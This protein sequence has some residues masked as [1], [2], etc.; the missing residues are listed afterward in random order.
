MTIICTLLYSLKCRTNLLIVLC[1]GLLSVLCLLSSCTEAICPETVTDIQ[2]DNWKVMNTGVT[3]TLR[4]VDFPG[5]G[6]IGYIC[7]TNGT[8]LKTM[9]GGQSFFSL[10]SGTTE[11]LYKVKFVT[12]DLGY[13]IGDNRTLIKTLD[14]GFTWSP[15][16][17]AKIPMYHLRAIHFFSKDTGIVAGHKG[18]IY[19]TTN[20]GASWETIDM[21]NPNLTVYSMMWPDFNNGFIG[22]NLGRLYEYKNGFNPSYLK[23]Y[24]FSYNCAILDFEML[25][26]SVSMLAVSD[27]QSPQF[28]KIESTSDG[29]NSFVNRYSSSA[30]DSIL[31]QSIKFLDRARGVAVGGGL[32]K[33]GTGLVLTSGD[34]G[35]SWSE[36]S[37]P[38]LPFLYDLSFTSNTVIAVGYKGKIVMSE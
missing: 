4:G 36:K 24:A 37:V 5:N 9:D 15:T 3:E 29:W 7:G 22:C 21:G 1:Y 10:S 13:V 26:D 31:F 17:L 19:R 23:Q 38:G 35:Q 8:I 6:D 28:K 2:A 27:L 32:L 18:Q 11:H 34:S 30:S 25:G 20:A 14:G 12:P 16:A 33:E